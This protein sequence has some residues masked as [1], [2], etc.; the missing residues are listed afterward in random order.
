MEELKG[1]VYPLAT[2]I[3]LGAVWGDLKRR[4]GNIERRQQEHDRDHREERYVSQDGL[5]RT[6]AACRGEW[7]DKLMDISET[8]KEIKQDIKDLRRGD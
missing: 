2:A 4:L 8:L 5:D 1:L 6:Q 7:K 3:G